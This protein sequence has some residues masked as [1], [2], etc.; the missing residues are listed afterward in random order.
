V[1]GS[2]ENDREGYIPLAKAMELAAE[3]RRA[4]KVEGINPRNKGMTFDTLFNRWIDGHAKVKKKSWEADVALYK[5]HIVK[6]LGDRETASLTGA[7]SQNAP[8]RERLFCS[9]GQEHRA[10]WHFDPPLRKV[11]ATF[12]SPLVPG[13]GEAG[14]EGM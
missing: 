4:V 2:S 6:R 8:R 3:R 5:H 10:W 1:F 13:L 11:I 7:Q 14:E 9:A 12:I